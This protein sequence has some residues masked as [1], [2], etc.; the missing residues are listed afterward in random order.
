MNIHEY[1]TKELF[2]NYKIPV[3]E[4]RM[5]HSANQALSVAEQLGGD[6]WVVKAQIHAGGRGKAGGVQLATNL[7]EVQEHAENLIGR[8]L[9][10]R[11]TGEVGRLVNR[12]LV[13]QVHQIDTE[14][15][16]GLVIDR[17]SQRITLIASAAGGMESIQKLK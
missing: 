5:A 14:Y 6:G 9:V 1:Q 2:R 10:T 11:Q 13:E 8:R 4:G 15:Y 12:V 16:L 7:E 3:P 17:G